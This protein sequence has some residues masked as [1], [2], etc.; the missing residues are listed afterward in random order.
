MSE[1]WFGKG[2]SFQCCAWEKSCGDP[3]YKEYTPVLIFCFHK[4]NKEDCEGNCTPEKCPL[5]N[6]I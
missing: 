3:N 6:K 1:K 5:E 2:C 4:E